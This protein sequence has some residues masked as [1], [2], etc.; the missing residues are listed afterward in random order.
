MASFNA[1]NE[2]QQ[3]YIGQYFVTW[4]YAI[5]YIRKWCNT[6]GF[7]IQTDRSK[8]NAKGEY[9]KLTLVCQHFG[10]SRKPLTELQMNKEKSKE[11]GNKSIKIDCKAYINLS[12]PEKD[13]GN[14]YVFVTTIF[15]KYCHKLNCQLVDYENGV[16]MTEKMLGDIEFLTKQ[17]HLS[18]IQQRL[19]LEE[20][21]SGQNIRSDILHKEIQKHY[22]LAKDLSNDASKLYEHFIELKENDIKWQIFVDLMKIKF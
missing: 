16:K 4:D 22:S 12:R 20:K 18:T 19:Y 7:Q 9:Q 5:E 2:Q 15:N 11:K 13:N 8:R 10:N 3:L 21:Y 14:K 6:Q 1:F 17:V